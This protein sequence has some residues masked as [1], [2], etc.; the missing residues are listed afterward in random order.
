MDR[1]P[2]SVAKEEHGKPKTDLDQDRPLTP[3]PL[4]RLPSRSEDSTISND[5]TDIAAVVLNEDDFSFFLKLP[6]GLRAEYLK[7]H[8]KTQRS[9]TTSTSTSTPIPITT[10]HPSNSVQLKLE[11]KPPAKYKG[12][13]DT[14]AINNFVYQITKYYEAVCADDNYVAKTIH[15]YL[16]SVALQWFQERER[17][18]NKTLFPSRW[19]LDAITKDLANAFRPLGRDGSSYKKL[20][21][22]T[23]KLPTTQANLTEFA[24]KFQN[25]S[26]AVQSEQPE[27][28]TGELMRLLRPK[29]I[30]YEEGLRAKPDEHYRSLMHYFDEAFNFQTTLTLRYQEQQQTMSAKRSSTSNS[31]SQPSTS[32]STNYD[33]KKSATSTQP[34]STSTKSDD[35]PKPKE[36]ISASD[37]MTFRREGRCFNCKQLGHIA[38]DPA[39][40]HFER[41]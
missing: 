2:F 20:T 5:L 21:E 41:E 37:R 11:I 39:C 27:I 18:L 12:T 29:L 23:M 22:L 25:L 8:L 35:K 3:T 30:K 17:S 15:M 31:R 13:R 10:S 7:K 19:T 4:S 36:T 34:T 40:P 32:S 33:K 38:T 26:M 14:V 9:S 1:T 16:D 24:E 6:D 28:T